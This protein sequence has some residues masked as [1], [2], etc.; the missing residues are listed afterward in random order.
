MKTNIKV[1][2]CFDGN[3]EAVDFFTDMIACDLSRCRLVTISY[4]K[5]DEGEIKI[6]KVSADTGGQVIKFDL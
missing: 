4:T 1:V 2:S 3:R 6:R 5:S